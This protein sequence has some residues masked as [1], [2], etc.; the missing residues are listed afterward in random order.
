MAGLRQAVQAGCD[1][2]RELKQQLAQA[3]QV[4]AVSGGGAGADSPGQN[5][6][7]GDGLSPGGMMRPLPRGPISKPKFR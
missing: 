4:A 2:R 7:G 3:Q 5:P 6:A 1:E